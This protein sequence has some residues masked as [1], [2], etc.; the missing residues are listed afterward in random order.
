MPMSLNQ[1][2]RQWIL[3]LVEANRTAVVEQLE[4]SFSEKLEGMETRLLTAFQKWASPV[5]IRQRADG[6]R[7]Q[8]LEL[9][10]Y[11]IKDRVD[12]LEGK[13]PQ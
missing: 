3:D 12:K 13:K 5:E 2:D 10:M 1:E 11:D 9:E 4:H 7:I 6:G 8:A